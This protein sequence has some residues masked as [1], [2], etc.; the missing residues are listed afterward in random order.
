MWTAKFLLRKFRVRNPRRQSQ[1]SQER[2]GRGLRRSRKR[3]CSPGAS[4]W[5]WAS[6]RKSSRS[7]LY[8]ARRVKTN[9]CQPRLAGSLAMRVVQMP[10]V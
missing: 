5:S 7:K 2:R 6:S 3:W 4:A 1:S 9:A 8:S 10:M